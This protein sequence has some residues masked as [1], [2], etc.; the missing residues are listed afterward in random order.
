VKPSTTTSF[1][2]VQAVAADEL[3]F[4]VLRQ[5]AHRWT[6]LDAEAAVVRYAE[7]PTRLLR[8]VSPARLGLVMLAPATAGAWLLPLAA[9]R[10]LRCWTLKMDARRFA[11]GVV[12]RPLRWLHRPLTTALAGNLEPALSEGKVVE[13]LAMFSALEDLAR[14][15]GALDLYQQAARAL[16]EPS[17]ELQAELE[18]RAG[19]PGSQTVLRL[20]WDKGKVQLLDFGLPGKPAQTKA[21]NLRLQVAATTD[22]RPIAEAVVPPTLTGWVYAVHDSTWVVRDVQ[23][24]AQQV[25]DQ[26]KSL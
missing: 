17:A 25:W 23:D 15:R 6:P 8:E 1:L 12:D 24:L 9:V 22:I 10:R 5:S 13:E 26:G 11:F 18:F 2:A 14:L 16:V 21:A 3:S 4:Y 20:R 19:P 7:L